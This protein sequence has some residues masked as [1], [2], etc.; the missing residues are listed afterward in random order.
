MNS[1]AQADLLQRLSRRSNE[2]DCQC[3][4]DIVEKFASSNYFETHFINAIER[5]SNIA[6][7]WKSAVRWMRRVFGMQN[8]SDQRRTIDVTPSKGKFQIV[9]RTRIGDKRKTR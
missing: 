3:C 5:L 2:L 4:L 6:L 9:E 7:C 1:K 8:P